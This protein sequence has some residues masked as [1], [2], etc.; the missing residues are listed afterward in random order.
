MELCYKGELRALRGSSMAFAHP[1]GKFN[2][3][4]MHSFLSLGIQDMAIRLDEISDRGIDFTISFYR[5]EKHYHLNPGETVT[6][7]EEG[8]AFACEL[9]FTIG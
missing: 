1:E 6:V 9:N 8:N 5:N 7:K 2:D 4:H 3:E